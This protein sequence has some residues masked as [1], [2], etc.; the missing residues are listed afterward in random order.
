MGGSNNP[1]GRERLPLQLASGQTA[2]FKL[3][4]TGTATDGLVVGLSQG[5]AGTAVYTT[6]V[7]YGGET[8]WWTADLAAGLNQLQ[9]LAQPANA[10]PLQYELTVVAVPT[11]SSASP[12]TWDGVSSSTGGTS[13]VRLNAPVAGIYHVRGDY[14]LGYANVLITGPQVSSK[15]A[16]QSLTGSISE[17][18]V[19]LGAGTYVFEVQQSQSQP[20]TSWTAKVSLTDAPVLTVTSISPS[21]INNKQAQADHRQR[22]QFPAGRHGRGGRCHG[23]SVTYVDSGTLTMLIPAGATP[24]TYGVKVTNPDTKS[25]LLPDSLT[26]TAGH[27]SV[28]TRYSCRRSSAS[29]SWPQCQNKRCSKWHSKRGERPLPPFCICRGTPCGC[30][31]A[32]HAQALP[33][34]TIGGFTGAVP[35]GALPCG[36]P[37]QGTHKG[38]CRFSCGTLRTE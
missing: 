16:A 35:L 8:F 24:G 25:A 17:F 12:Q 20:T 18:D 11:L 26:I 37:G 27:R 19:T 29:K 21:R 15:V 9:L 28:T 38:L 22:H 2:N 31:R 3:K 34:P 5:L 4:L 23:T 32:G 10:S 36:G 33:P 6:P 7:V 14:G 30:L 1:F 13:K